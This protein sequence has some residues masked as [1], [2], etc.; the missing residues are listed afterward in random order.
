MRG[1]IGLALFVSIGGSVLW[2][3]LQKKMMADPGRLLAVAIG[4]TQGDDM[5]LQI[6]VGPRT[7]AT[8]PPEM[9]NGKAQT[10]PEWS[11]AHYQLYDAANQRI[12]LR[13]M[14]TS[15]LMLNKVAAGAPEFVL[16]TNVKK[17][18]TYYCD[19]V[20]VVA[21]GTKYRYTFEVPDEPVDVGRR[22]FVLVEEDEG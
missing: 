9:Q 15:A 21:K 2:V 5:Q 10:W 22:N 18:E 13:R 16:W 1:V 7:I 19:F 20:P 14:G 8:D 3:T 6:G 17:G 4:N 11:K 12:D